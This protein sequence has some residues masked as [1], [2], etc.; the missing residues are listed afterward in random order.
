MARAQM[1]VAYVRDLQST[2]NLSGW[3][4]AVS[5]AY[6]QFTLLCYPGGSGK[7]LQEVLLRLEQAAMNDEK[8]EFLRQYENAHR[9][10]P[11][12]AKVA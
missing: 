5:L 7:M 9:G 6:D 4:E 3:K 1:M 10:A 12:P 2:R 8:Y 11:L